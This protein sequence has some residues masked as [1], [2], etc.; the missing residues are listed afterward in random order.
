M[1]L[2]TF[3]KGSASL[4]CTKLQSL[5]VPKLCLHPS[6]LFF[7][8]AN[9]LRSLAARTSTKLNK[10]G[11]VLA[12]NRLQE[13]NRFLTSLVFVQAQILLFSGTTA[14]G[15][16]RCPK[17]QEEFVP[18]ASFSHF[19]SLSPADLATPCAKELMNSLD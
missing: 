12:F 15:N 19:A 13:L 14:S 17:H 3:K 11:S 7:M 2:D 5:A 18:I 9:V 4:R 1:S 6:N 8:M 10:N 16:I